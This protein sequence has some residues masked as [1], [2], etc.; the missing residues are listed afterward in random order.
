MS[1]TVA[2]AC[3]CIGPQPGQAECPC[4]LRQRSIG[5]VAEQLKERFREKIE[6]S[7]EQPFE[8][9]GVVMPKDELWLDYARV[10]VE[11]MGVGER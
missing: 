2:M 3:A 5:R 6:K 8:E 9:T 11:A 10:A 1:Q 7:A 4:I